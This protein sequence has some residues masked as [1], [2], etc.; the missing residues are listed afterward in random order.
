MEEREL[1]SEENVSKNP[2]ID[3]LKSLGYIYLSATDATL[4]RD[5]TYNVLLTDILKKQI[6]VLNSY[7][8]KGEE[9]SFS[10]KN[11]EQAIRD[12]NHPLTAGLV[13]TNEKIYDDLMLGK[14]YEEYLPDGNKS[15]FTLKYIDWNTPENNVYHV[16]DEFTV[17]R[18][19]GRSFKRPDIVLFVNGIPFATIECKRSSIDIQQ[20]IE[21][22][23]AYQ[24][25]NN[26]PHLYKFIQIVMVSNKNESK[27]GT[28]GTP[29]RFW[30]I[31]REEYEDW[32]QEKI[33]I[34]IHGRMA[35]NQDQRII[36][37][38]SP[39]R[40]L[41]LTRYFL[42]F[43]KNEKK[44]ARYQQYF[45]VRETI[46]SITS[47]DKR[48]LRKGGIIWHTQGSG[49]S[50]TMVMLSNYIL[51]NITDS[52][53]IVVTDRINLDKQIKNTFAHTRLT[54][55]RASS[56]KNLVDLINDKKADIITTLVHKFDTASKSNF[57]IE[58]RDIFVLVD[59][60]HRTQY[61]E[62]HT[63][64]RL[65]FPNACYLGFTG[66]PLMKKEKNTMVKFGQ[67]RPI[68]TYT[69]A[70]GVEDK[71]IVPL[72]YEGKMIKQIVNQKAI[73]NRLAMITRN[74]NDKH[75]EE[76][77][78]K[79]SR[80]EKIASSDQRIQFIAFDI[81]EHFLN[82]YKIEGFHFK[83][84]LATNGRKQAI[85]YLEAFKELGDL[86]AAVVIS[87]P[88]QREGQVEVDVLSEDKVLEFWNKMMEKYGD[89]DNY[90][91]TIKNEFLDGELDLLIV[92]DKL[93]TG[94]DA[95]KATV[96]YIDKQMR[97]HSLLQAIARVNRLHEGKDYGHIIDY[98]GL[99]KE[100]DEA[101]QI[102]SGSG[103]ENFDPEDLK[104]ALFDV[105]MIIGKLRQAHSRLLDIFIPVKNKNDVEEYELRLANREIREEYY[106][107]L[108]NFSKNL[109][110]AL[111]SEKI[112]E[113]LGREQ[114]GLY[115]K[116][117]KFF[118]K[119]RQSVKLRYSDNIDYKEYQGK[120]QNLMDTYI[121][122]E[123]VIRITNPVDILNE[124]GIE[125]E[126]ERLNTPRAK[127]DAI[128][129]RISKRI[130]IKW[131]ED[132][133]FYKKFSE[134]IKETLD[135]YENK[136][137]SER[138]YLE[139]MQKLRTDFKS[140]NSGIQYPEN[141][142][143]NKDAQAFYGVVVNIVGRNNDLNN[144]KEL[145]AE[146][147]FNL[148]KIIAKHSKVDWH[149]NIEVHKRIE[150]DIDDLLF[151]FININDIDLSFEEIDEIIDNVKMLALNRY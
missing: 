147:S 120:M 46:K 129:T 13:K 7:E 89:E 4:K 102:Y 98:I 5:N 84:M 145:V 2:A 97:E 115:K 49:K 32:L 19:D 133:A 95:P 52:Q 150:Q 66:T 24:N 68:H 121:V 63:K 72:L 132:P 65:V 29:A 103:L 101:M 91:E 77:K 14:S 69:I 125:K 76:V 74:L 62:L 27:Y 88:D 109:S 83:A 93:L 28:C 58:D 100:L 67:R 61:G 148:D 122:S 1:Y 87:S 41:E 8:Y 42:V 142:R 10:D 51:A 135:D 149:D 15:S 96:L 45:A 128:R 36:S 60:S 131:D 151:D 38:F 118:Q 73:D 140:G 81:N 35:T 127:A 106:K 16:V 59:E 108:N 79:W 34:H 50:L 110:I 130:D 111:E 44:I 123:E 134:K 21:Q 126:L 137:I 78:Q 113:A 75:T 64:M 94:F 143:R 53:V 37:L 144:R 85:R 25:N 11:I 3:V 146:L 86:N 9:Y 40:F 30:S 105:K 119:L 39:E 104:G 99:I 6:K 139:K 80:F 71:T 31:W 20:G 82:N 43:D 22:T 141:I 70:D 17:E 56:G 57:K 12:I 136:R 107:V 47:F 138:E 48:G 33:N 18:A 26:I 124:E 90:E 23:I 92:V 117:L 55:N 116:E 112:Y 114:L 54:P